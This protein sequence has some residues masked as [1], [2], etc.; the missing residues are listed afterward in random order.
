MTDDITTVDTCIL[1]VRTRVF[2][3][4]QIVVVLATKIGLY[5]FST[6]N[7]TPWSLNALF[8]AFFSTSSCRD[9]FGILDSSVVTTSFMSSTSSEQS[10]L[11]KV[12]VMFFSSR[13]CLVFRPLWVGVLLWILNQANVLLVDLLVYSLWPTLEFGT[14]RFYF[15]DATFMTPILEL[16]SHTSYHK[17]ILLIIPALSH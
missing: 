7:K 3:Y 4:S 16:V 6:S 2:A 8:P 15:G 1:A 17:L 9:S 14:H 13:N 12:K 11:K 10:T 5:K